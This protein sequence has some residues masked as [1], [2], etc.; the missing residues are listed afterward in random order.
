MPALLLSTLLAAMP[1]APAA[2]EPLPTLSLEDGRALYPRTEPNAQARWLEDLARDLGIPLAG[3]GPA[4]LAWW[5]A[6][7]PLD[8]VLDY[9]SRQLARPETWLDEPDE[10]VLAYS[11]ASATG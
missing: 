6:D 2:V 8:A 4:W 1:P 5:R 7:G 9:A 3:D 11:M 10:P